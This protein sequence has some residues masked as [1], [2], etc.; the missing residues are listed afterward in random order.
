[1]LHGDTVVHKHVAGDSFGESS[2]LFEKPRSLVY[3]A[4]EFR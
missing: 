4:F 3:I 1:M 2:L